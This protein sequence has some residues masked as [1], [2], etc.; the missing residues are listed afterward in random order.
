MPDLLQPPGRPISYHP[1]LTKLVG[2]IKAAILLQQITYWTPRAHDADGWIYKSEKA[3]ME[4][5]GY[6]L[7]ELRG[8]MQELLTRKFIKREYDRTRHEL[9]VQLQVETYNSAIQGLCE[10]R[11]KEHMPKENVLKRHVLKGNVAHTKRE[12]AIYQKGT[13]TYNVVSRDDTEMTPE[14]ITPPSPSRSRERVL[15]GFAEFWPKYPKKKN[16][17][18]AERAWAVIHPDFTLRQR[19][20]T[21]LEE[22]RRSQEW[23][24]ERGRFIPYPATWLRAKGWEDEYLAPEQPSTLWTEPIDETE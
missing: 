21:A 1:E 17:G 13:C 4:E 8:A 3:W 5:I 16:K 22:A 6:T 11:T 15:E 14:M 23:L 2:S 7:K 24:R 12:P 9:R 18:D 19:I 20:L 10:Q